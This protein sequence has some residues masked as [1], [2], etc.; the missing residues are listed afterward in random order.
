[1]NVRISFNWWD[2]QFRSHAQVIEFETPVGNDLKWPRHIDSQKP[3]LFPNAFNNKAVKRPV[4]KKD[5]EQRSAVISPIVGNTAQ[6]TP[7]KY[8]G[9]HKPG[10]TRFGWNV[11]LTELKSV[12]LLHTRQK[13]RE[14]QRLIILRVTR[15]SEKFNLHLRWLRC[16]RAHVK[17][18]FFLPI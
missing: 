18:S 12:V 13:R 7:S 9:L 1:M 8:C 11:S 10:W 16:L 3:T 5:T 17:Q 6:P 4:W 15:A 2:W 14:V